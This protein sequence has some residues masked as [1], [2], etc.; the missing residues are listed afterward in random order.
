MTFLNP[1][2]L[3]GLATASIP[4][5]LHLL[6]LRKLRSVDFSTLQFLK[7]LQKTKIRRL[8]LKQIILLILRM[9]IIIFAVL[10]FSR[11]VVKTS[12]PALGAHIKSSIVIVA[13]NS[14]S[15]EVSD[16]G[17]NRLNQARAAALSV[18]S[19]LKDGDEA[20]LLTLSDVQSERSYSLSRNFSLLREEI[21]GMKAGYAPV[22]LEDGLRKAQKILQSSVN[23]NKEIYIITDA[24]QNIFVRKQHDSLRM[25]DEKTA[26]FVVPIHTSDIADANLTIDSI[27]V[28]NRIF[29]LDKPVE[30]EALIRNSGKNEAK[31]VS[32]GLTFDGQRVAQRSAD[33]PA[34]SVRSVNIV[35]TPHKSGIIQAA[36]ELEPDALEADNKRYFGFIIADKPRVA[37]FG[38]SEQI[39]FLSLLFSA[40][41]E[42]ANI[43]KFPA[44]VLG[45]TALQNYDAIITA[46]DITVSDAVRIHAYI[47]G[48]GG[49]LI[50]ANEHNATIYSAFG[51][52]TAGLQNY[53]QN[54]PAQI[55][56]IDKKH[57]LFEGV[58]KGTT[59]A[60]RLAESPKII[61]A[62]PL[63][64]GQVL[65]SMT[66]GG[67]F[68]AEQRIGEG[69]LLACA[70]A[71]IASWGNFPLTGMFPAIVVRSLSYASVRESF[72]KQF[73]VGDQPS[74]TLP[75]RYS[76]GGNFKVIDPSGTESLRPAVDLPSGSSISL[77]TVSQP[78]VYRI[79][80]IEGKPVAV[81]TANTT[82][83]EGNLIY[84]SQDDLLSHI[85]G[86]VSPQTPVEIITDTKAVAEGAARA[87]IGSELWKACIIAALLCAIA[88]M[89]VARASRAESV[90]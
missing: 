71:P 5:L 82:D 34:G 42:V 36:I 46:C 90:A 77:G 39:K 48:G 30:A 43:E 89:I 81:A 20:A 24:Q 22:S 32:I 18:I 80:S 60:N 59:D 14:F 28:A 73:I 53:D 13:D 56:S 52:S 44:E 68:L 55:T 7:E 31:G 75:K 10:A 51:F 21:N 67:A 27:N 38:N 33:I 17:G 25:F 65:I 1:L 85:H 54:Q 83:N 50:F 29:S 79:Y 8:K 3:L 19:V 11:P 37:L 26:V 78:G 12:L 88:E 23:L 45:G 4:L 2:V 40:N 47:S 86:F 61:K 74:I 16:A 64:G 6:N 72:G 87:R 41:A 49:S 57:P 58:F 84:A 62:L 69:R 9:L 35:A 76:G 15:M 66:G 63:N 70:V